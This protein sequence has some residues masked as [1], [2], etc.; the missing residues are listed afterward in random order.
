MRQ[1]INV[2]CLCLCAVL[3]AR[4]ARQTPAQQL[5]A[6]MMPP[7]GTVGEVHP[8]SLIKGYYRGWMTSTE[9]AAFDDKNYDLFNTLADAYNSEHGFPKKR[10]RKMS[11]RERERESEYIQYYEYN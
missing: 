9:S 11:A 8:D 2:F 5:M 7:D 1:L 6:W 10:K 4:A 3:R